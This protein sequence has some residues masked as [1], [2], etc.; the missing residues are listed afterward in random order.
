[1]CISRLR[2]RGRSGCSVAE[3]RVWP[4]LVAGTQHPDSRRSCCL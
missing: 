4:R 1:M 2:D 3:L